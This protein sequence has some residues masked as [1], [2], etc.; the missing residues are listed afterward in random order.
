MIFF[1]EGSKASYYNGISKRLE[2]IDNRFGRQKV[3]KEFY[4]NFIKTAFPKTAE[5]LGVAYTPSEIVDF[6]LKSANEILKSEFNKGLTDKG[7]HVI[8]A[9][10]GIGSFIRR[11]IQ[12][13]HIIEKKIY[14][15]N[16]RMNSM[17][18]K[19]YFYL[20]IYLLFTL[21]MPIT[22]ECV[23]GGRVITPLFL[24]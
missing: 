6:I 3:I 15:G 2:G 4:E 19:Y 1:K 9:F 16:L 20:I 11:L 24:E 8:D 14:H 10:A 21:R 12:M 7:V 5:K 22:V 18:T 17:L 13:D 23:L